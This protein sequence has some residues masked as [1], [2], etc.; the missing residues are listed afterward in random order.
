MKKLPLILAI[1]SAVVVAFLVVYP[2]F[3]HGSTGGPD[4]LESVRTG[5][6]DAD[7]IKSIQII[8]PDDPTTPFN[9][10]EIEKMKTEQTIT[11]KA[12][13]EAFLRS[14]SEFGKDRI[15]Q[16]HPSEDFRRY[17]RVNTS[18]GFYLVYCDVYSDRSSSQFTFESN[19]L[20]ATNPNSATAYYGTNFQNLLNI[21]TLKDKNTEQDGG[22][23]PATRSESK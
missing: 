18:K 20:N 9:L 3:I 13:I 2:T 5:S 17:L 19:T 6:V 8:I 10:D 1:V 11:E 22:G 14:L 23:Q 21:L 15:H 12:N 4:F 16:N 7:S